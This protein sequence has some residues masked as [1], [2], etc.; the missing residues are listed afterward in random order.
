MLVIDHCQ[1]E[2]VSQELIDCYQAEMVSQELIDSLLTHCCQAEMV[3]P[4]LGIHYLLVIQG[5][6]VSQEGGYLLLLNGN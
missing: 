6:I 2:M 1:A 5:W 3:S 4:Q